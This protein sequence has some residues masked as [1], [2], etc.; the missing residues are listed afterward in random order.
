M[1]AAVMCLSSICLCATWAVQ[2]RK[3]E[4]LECGPLLGADV[5]VSD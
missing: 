5:D 3:R 1:A 4:V 2:R